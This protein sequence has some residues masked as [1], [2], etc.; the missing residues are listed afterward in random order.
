MKMG[1][2][3][4]LYMFKNINTKEYLNNYKNDYTIIRI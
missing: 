3:S 4:Y 1:V 2:V